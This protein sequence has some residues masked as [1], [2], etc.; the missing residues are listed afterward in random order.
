[1]IDIKVSILKWLYGLT[2][3]V[4]G[5]GAASVSAGISVTVLNPTDFEMLGHRQLKLMMLV[6]VISGI[7]HAFFYLKQSPLPDIQWDKIERRSGPRT[8][9][10]KETVK[11]TQVDPDTKIKETEKTTTTSDLDKEKKDEKA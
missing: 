11:E 4:I 3:A 6:F 2:A 7:T 10:V 1:M 8:V 9:E 5:G